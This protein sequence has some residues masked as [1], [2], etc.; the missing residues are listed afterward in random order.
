MISL[1]LDEGGVSYWLPGQFGSLAPV[2]CSPGWSLGGVHYHADTSANGGHLFL[3][4][5]RIAAALDVAADLLILA[6]GYTFSLSSLAIPE[7]ALNTDGSV[8]LYFK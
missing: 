7:M 1:Q 6:P 5:G 3:R 8:D 4:G 2:P